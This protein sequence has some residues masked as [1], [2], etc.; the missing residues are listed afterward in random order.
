MYLSKDIVKEGSTLLKEKCTNVKM[1]LSSSDLEV[2]KGLNEY[3]VISDN[4]ELTEKYKIRPGVGIAAPQVGVLKRMFA[5]NFEDFLDENRKKY[6]MAVINPVITSASKLMVYLP[7]GEGC[8][9]VDRKTTGVTPRHYAI[10]IKAT[11]YDF[12]NNKAKTI[13]EKLEGFPAIV[14]Q[15]EYDHLDGILFTDK[16]ITDIPDDVLPLYT[17]DESDNNDDESK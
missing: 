16:I 8:L 4:E 13:T 9:S 15:H 14:F 6:S 2:L 7:N 17:I 11:V 3:M 12:V 10:T 1:P 5:I